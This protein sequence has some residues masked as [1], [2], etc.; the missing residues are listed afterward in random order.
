MNEIKVYQYDHDTRPVDER[1]DIIDLRNDEHLINN[2]INYREGYYCILLLEQG[3]AFLEVNGYTKHVQAPVVVCGLPGD[4][5]HWKNFKNLRGRFVC[6]EG[7]FI[8]AGLNGGFTLEP[9]SFLNMGSHFPFIPLSYSRYHKLRELVNDMQECRN[10][11]PVFYDLL[12]VQLWQFIFLTEKE[13]ILNR[14]KGRETEVKNHIVDFMHLVNNHYFEHHD[15]KYYAEKMCITPNYLNKVC[16][17]MIGINAYDY[18]SSRIMAE[19]KV[20]L[21]LT[22]ITV[23]ELAYRLGFENVNYFIKCFKKSEGVTPGEY[24]KRGTLVQSPKA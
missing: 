8:L 5:W 18:I 6:F 4:M 17:M 24:K 20:L 13:Y 3:E 23:N 21:R 19:A 22:D 9:V 2:E 10:E 16:K 7:P 11:Y 1:F 15:T 12:R 14:Q